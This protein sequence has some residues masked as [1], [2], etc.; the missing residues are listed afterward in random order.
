[1]IVERL[2]LRG[3]GGEKDGVS[4][5]GK[6]VRWWVA[7]GCCGVFVLLYVFVYVCTVCSRAEAHVQGTVLDL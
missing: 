5:S 3:M 2:M 6:D 7:G 4:F 1:M